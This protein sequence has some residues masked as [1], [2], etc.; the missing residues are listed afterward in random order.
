MTTP[1]L[2]TGSPRRSTSAIGGG[3]VVDS[4][5]A[6]IRPIG[7]GTRREVVEAR[8]V[9]TGRPVVLKLLRRG[10]IS[11]GE[12]VKRLGREARAL[13]AVEH[14]GVVTIFDAGICKVHGPFLVLERLEGRTLD[15]LLAAR[16][17]LEPD[18]VLS[19][20]RRSALAL[21]EVHR[22]G[23]VHRDIKP[24]NV[25]IASTRMGVEVLKLIDFAHSGEVNVAPRSPTVPMEEIVDLADLQKLEEL[26][27]MLGDPRMDLYA[28][29]ELVATCLGVEPGELLE[30]LSSAK[31]GRALLGHR[32][33]LPEELLDI[34]DALL[35]T[36]PSARPKTADAV[37]AML[38]DLGEQPHQLLSFPHEEIAIDYGSKRRPSPARRRHLRAPY[39]TPVRIV[40]EDEHIDGRTEDISS[41]GLLVLAFGPAELRGLR[42]VRF[43]L[44]TTGRVVEVRAVA[45][46]RRERAGRTAI[47]LEFV[48]IDA[49]SAEAIE[50][51]ARY[52]AVER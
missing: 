27:P 42:T 10:E 31:R 15:G 41:S 9:Q 22:R 43:A 4:R 52:L 12:G 39:I 18:D 45:K 28:L 26:V 3:P 25:F 32:K 37:L 6:I 40:G 14:P 29:G 20:L 2:H 38:G 48:D 8:H 7:R 17:A 35:A 30:S 50:R 21:A 49:T 1:E 13:G 46:W 51:Y 11:R 16:G 47:G 44:P 36:S 19:L 23:F 5:Y 33:D 34:L 24:A